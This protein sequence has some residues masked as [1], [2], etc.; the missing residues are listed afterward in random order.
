MKLEPVLTEKSLDLAKE[1]KYTFW[2]GKNLTK[3]QI[4]K[5]VGQVFGVQVNKVRTMNVAGETKRT[6]LGRKRVIKP[7]KKA[8]V[9]LGA[10]DKIDLFET[11]K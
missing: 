2:V 6:V 5:L 8:I 7:R 10:K 4:A 3:H 11:K 9:E 1:G